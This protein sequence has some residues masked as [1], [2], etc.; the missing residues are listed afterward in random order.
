MGNNLKEERKERRKRNNGVN[1]MDGYEIG[2]DMAAFGQELE[3][4]KLLL[5]QLYEV[6]EHNLK[7]GKLEEPK[8]NKK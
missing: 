4:T 7:Q 2:K 8:A 5:Q 6:V 1:K 3:N